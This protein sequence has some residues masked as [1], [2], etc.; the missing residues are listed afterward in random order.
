MALNDF[1]EWLKLRGTL[2]CPFKSHF[3]LLPLTQWEKSACEM[4]MSVDEIQGKIFKCSE[5]SCDLAPRA[6]PGRHGAAVLMFFSNVD[7]RWW[8]TVSRK[9]IASRCVM[10]AISIF[11]LPTGHGDHQH[12]HSY[13][14]HCGHSRQNGLHRD[15]RGSHGRLDLCAVQVVEWR[16]CKGTVNHISS[17]PVPGRCNS[18]QM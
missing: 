13:R 3:L 6:S 12:G 5:M 8:N 7:P 2:F 15:E 16:H 17:M 9:E 4:K 14:T 10:N 18:G 11:S 1:P